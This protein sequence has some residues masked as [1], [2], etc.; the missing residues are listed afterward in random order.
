M[1]KIF[2]S[3]SYN[4]PSRFL[5]EIPKDL[6]DGYDEVF[7]D[8]KREDSFEDSGYSWKYGK[9]SGSSSWNKNG[10]SYSGENWNK[11][12]SSYSGGNFSRSVSVNGNANGRVVTHRISNDDKI[13]ETNS[14]PFKRTAESFLANLNARN[15]SNVDISKYKVGQNVFHKKF[16]KGKIVKLDPEGDDIKVDLEFEKF[17]HKRLMAKFAGLEIID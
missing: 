13:E 2:G 9:S 16:G 10:E 1:R 8:R 11:S 5:K 14:S 12:N 17:G 4:P 7:E 6:L 3:T 15:N